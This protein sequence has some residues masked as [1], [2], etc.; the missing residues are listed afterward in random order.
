M[1]R[2]QRRFP[3][4]GYPI[5]VVYK[6]F[7]DLGNFMAALFAYYA[8][9]SLF[10]MLI[11]ATTILGVVLEGNPGL[12]QE[13]IRSALS[14][15][16]IVGDEIKAPSASTGSWISIAV[17]AL[18]AL[19]GALG[20]AQAFQ[21]I[22]NSVWQ[23]PRNSRPNPFAAR[24]KSV[25]LI[26]VLGTTLLATIGLTSVVPRVIHLAGLAAFGVRVGT[27]CVDILAI[28]FA[29]RIATARRIKTRDL[30]PGAVFAG[31]MWQVLQT[32]GGIYVEHVVQR[33]T[34]IAGQ[35]AV[36]VG[37][38]I[39]LYIA[40][41]AIAMSMEIDAV[42]VLRLWP[43]ALL[44]PFTDNVRLTAGDIRAYTG[45]AEATRLKGFERINV[46]FDRSTDPVEDS[47]DHEEVEL[48]LD[49]D[50]DGS[51]GNEV[52][53][54]PPHPSTPQHRLPERPAS[55]DDDDFDPGSQPTIPLVT[56]RRPAE[57]DSDDSSIVRGP[58]SKGG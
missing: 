19:Y 48:P 18:V 2:T 31:L 52:E 50:D 20:A 1:D 29:F 44:T 54:V 13:L 57:A 7:D 37:L 11:L 28:T 43:R 22:A 9:V 26:A 15:F 23:V 39:F 25:G 41:V 34:A 3:P 40:G 6:F 4:L 10:P 17:S 38:M 45:L 16:P 30:L 53:A 32:V 35:F 27:I 33:N 36:V 24:G 49:F 8:F 46:T 12:Q 56:R 21:Y 5:A 42:R 14:E 51:P 58:W 47:A 55:D